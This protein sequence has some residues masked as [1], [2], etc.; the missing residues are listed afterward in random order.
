MGKSEKKVFLVGLMGAGKTTIGKQLAAVLGFEFFDSDHEIESHTGATIPL[1]FELEGESGFRERE[2]Y[3]INELTKRENIVLATGGGAVLRE[4]NRQLLSERG[5][6]IYLSATVEQLYKRTKWDKNRPLLQTDDPKTKLL[7]L[8]NARD[9]L[10]REIAD[11]TVDTGKGSIKSTVNF[12]K[13]K[14]AS[15]RQS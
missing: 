6:V 3:I 2:N 13:K 10:Y 5:I 15:V 4:D 11:I 14:L 8:L 9:P 7:E 1:I 12:I